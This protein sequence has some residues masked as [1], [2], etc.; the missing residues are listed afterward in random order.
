MADRSDRQW[1]ARAVADAQ[2][3]L[4]AGDTAR[5]VELTRQVLRAVPA[6][7]SADRDQARLLLG[8]ALVR[9]GN[10]SARP[11]AEPLLARVLAG[12]STVPPALMGILY[13][14]AVLRDPASE[15]ATLATAASTARRLLGMVAPRERDQQWWRLAAM[16]LRVGA[17]LGDVAGAIAEGRSRL[18]V[19]QAADEEAPSTPAGVA[20]VHWVLGELLQQRGEYA[21]A[22]THLAL[23][24]DLHPR[25]DGGDGLATDGVGVQSAYARGLLRARPHQSA[26]AADLL[27][28]WRRPTWQ[29]GG[30]LYRRQWMLARAEIAVAD[31]RSASA[32]TI[33]S[34]LLESA[35]PPQLQV[36]GWVLLGVGRASTG[37]TVEAAQAFGTAEAALRRLPQRWDAARLWLSVSDGWKRI[38]Y[39]AACDEAMRHAVAAALHPGTSPPPAP[40]DR[41]SSPRQPTDGAASPPGGR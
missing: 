38:G 12:R 20:A 32:E 3:A 41:L 30:A 24:R 14:G 8:A 36:E 31:G 37:R 40:P 9:D 33:L 19:M 29:Y 35:A 5:V 34:P 18:D 25:G 10:L 4:F 21:N 2:A 26:E 11:E 23:A 27:D 17:A 7:P 6:A 15:Q 22:L 1:T 13:L 39:T 28:R 16:S